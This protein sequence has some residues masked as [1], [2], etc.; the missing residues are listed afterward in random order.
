MPLQAHGGQAERPF[1]R[2]GSFL[3]PRTPP[4]F[5]GPQLCYAA[6]AAL[7]AC[8]RGNA[9]APVPTLNSTVEAE[10]HQP[11]ARL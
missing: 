5:S 8:G 7:P 4:S 11:G 10:V 1:A 3:P 2:G 6:R 9:A